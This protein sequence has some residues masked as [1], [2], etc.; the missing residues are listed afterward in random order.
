MAGQDQYSTSMFR[1]AFKAIT[2]AANGGDFIAYQGPFDEAIISCLGTETTNI[3]TL[4]MPGVANAIKSLNIT[5]N[6]HGQVA[7][8][9]GAALYDLFR[10]FWGN[11]FYF[12]QLAATTD[13]NCGMVGALPIT[14]DEDESL[15]FT[16]TF[17]A[18][19]DMDSG[20]TAYTA[21]VRMSFRILNQ[22]SPT[23]Y[24]AYRVQAFVAA[25]AQT[26]Q[27]PLPP[28]LSGYSLVGEVIEAHPTSLTA[29]SD[30][31][32]T[33][34][35]IQLYQGTIPIVD[36]YAMTLLGAYFRRIFNMLSTAALGSAITCAAGTVLYIKHIPVSNN[37]A[38]V[39]A[40][41]TLAQV[42]SQSQIV[43][44]Y[45]SGQVSPAFGGGTPAVQPTTEV[46]SNRGALVPNASGTPTIQ[47][48]VGPAGGKGILEYLR[49]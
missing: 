1:K 45:Q 48:K 42:Y 5:S 34:G 15:N 47:A 24:W 4:T 17:G 33:L 23:T 31:V 41:Q 16:Y 46:P 29:A 6:K 32:A 18:L 10:A 13:T 8:L 7:L 19:T 30:P 39:F 49:Q 35:L 22:S 43:Y 40:I 14:A 2:W 38:S 36:E 20:I 12:R 9:N 25:G 37:D 28:I 44:I 21:T 27:Q 11:G 26:V 3:T